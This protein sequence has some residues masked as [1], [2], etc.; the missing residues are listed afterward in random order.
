MATK[1][2]EAKIT[3]EQMV[4]AKRLE[5]VMRTPA[6]GTK[7]SNPLAFINEQMRI[8]KRASKTAAKKGG[9]R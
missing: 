3:K 6:A 4:R 8:A 1:T 2:T 5:D 9:A 7:P